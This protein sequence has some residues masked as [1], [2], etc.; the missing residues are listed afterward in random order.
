L[1]RYFASVL[2]AVLLFASAVHASPFCDDFTDAAEELDLIYVDIADPL[3]ERVAQPLEAA[4]LAG[5]IAEV[6]PGPLQKLYCRIGMFEMDVRFFQ[7]AEDDAILGGVTQ[8]IYTWDADQDPSGWVLTGLRRQYA[9]ARGAATFT[10]I[11][12]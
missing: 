2:G 12:P 10:D 1:I 6:A 3:A 5:Q 8:A 11:C 9:C 7:P 4:L